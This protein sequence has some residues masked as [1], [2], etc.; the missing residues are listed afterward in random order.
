MRHGALHVKLSERPL[1]SLSITYSPEVSVATFHE[2]VTMRMFTSTKQLSM[3]K[4]MFDPPS[5]GVRVNRSLTRTLFMRV[6]SH[7][8]FDTRL[9]EH[10]TVDLSSGNTK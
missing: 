10:N 5:S 9:V 7:L 3:V 6:K 8:A 4:V 2:S 1:V